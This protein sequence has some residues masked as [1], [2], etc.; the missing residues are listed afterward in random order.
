MSLLLDYDA[1]GVLGDPM[2]YSFS[3][4]ENN[5]HGEKIYQ[6]GQ[7]SMDAQSLVI[8]FYKKYFLIFSLQSF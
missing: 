3:L 7:T 6:M 2:R 1:G 8:H 4:T 5:G